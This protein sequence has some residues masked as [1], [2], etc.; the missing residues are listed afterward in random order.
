MRVFWLAL[1]VP[2]FAADYSFER[3]QTFLKSYCAACHTGKA[4]VGGF[5]LDQVSV[6]ES[7]TGEAQRWTA[8]LRRVRNAEM[9]PKGAPAP[10]LDESEAFAKWAERALHTAACAG[11]I[12]PGP[13]RIRRLNRDEYSATL[14]DLLDMHLDLGASLPVDGGGGEGFDNAAETLFLSPLHSEKYMD[15]AKFATEFAAKE[16]KS[17]NKIL[18][19]KPG[20]GLPE[21]QAARTILAN[22]LPRAFRRPVPEA[23]AAPYMALFHT[24]RRQGRTFD[25]AIFFTLRGVL[26][27]PNFLFLVEPPNETGAVRLLG[28]YELA[29][30][31]SYFLWGSMP[32]EFLTDLAAAGKLHDPVVQKVLVGRMLRNDRS[33]AFVQRFVDQWLGIRDLA[34]SKKPDA[35]LYPMFEKDEELRSDIVLQPALFFREILTR[36]LSVLDLIDSKYTV[37]TRNL[38]T[39]LDVKFPLNRAQ[40]KQPQFVEA[41]PESARGGLLAMPAIHA[42]SSYPYRTS[43]VLRGAWILD[44]I[45]GAPPPP[46]PPNVPALEEPTAGAATKTMRE[47]LALHRS[48]AVCASCHNRIDGI[49]FALENYDVLG[50]WRNEEA[51]MPIDNTGELNGK[52]FR[53]PVELRAY[54]LTRQDEFLRHLTAKMLGFA[55]GR[56][57]TLNDACTVDLIVERVKNDSYRSQTLITEIVASVPFRYQAPASAVRKEPVR[58]P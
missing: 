43:P 42:V 47:R 14:R 51:G 9:P 55:L 24:A 7:L 8:L 4:A 10:P 45:L 41:P 33:L 20:P 39:F 28:Q 19:A 15:A 22:F 18:I 40:A 29:S 32:D 17:R 2:A 50:R 26:V 37:A 31:I 13:S 57:L 11:G 53:G 3:G 38:E 27:S 56:G 6:S 21:A 25:E 54:L 35:K 16:F 48:N 5:K 1:A 36:N 12:Q 49:G 44:A 46:P 52:T 30:R 34:G 58:T 23:D